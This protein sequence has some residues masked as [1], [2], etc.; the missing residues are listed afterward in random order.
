MKA[1]PNSPIKKLVLHFDLNKT[2]LFLDSAQN[3]SKDQI[4]LFF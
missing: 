4:V 2:I 3:L 1:I